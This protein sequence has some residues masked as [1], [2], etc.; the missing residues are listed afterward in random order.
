M[1]DIGKWKIRETLWEGGKKM[2]VKGR[3]SG[4]KGNKDEK[5]REKG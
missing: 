3:E 4:R 2:D 5:K 1:K